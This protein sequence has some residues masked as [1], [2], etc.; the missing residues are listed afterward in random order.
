M[1]GRGSPSSHTVFFQDLKT[2][3]EIKLRILTKYSDA[4]Q[5][6]RGSTSGKLYYVDGFAGAGWYGDQVSEGKEGSPVRLA[7]LA[8]QIADSSKPYRLICLNCEVDHQNFSRLQQA[9]AGFDKEIVH[10][11]SGSFE[12]HLPDILKEIGRWPAV[13]FLDPFG[14]SPINLVNLHPIL[15]RPDTE[16]LLNLNTPS[17]RRIAGFADSQSNQRNAKLRIVSQVLGDDPTDPKPE[18]LDT[19]HRIAPIEWEKWAAA[20][21]IKRLQARSDYLRYALAYPIRETFRSNPKYYLVFATR[22]F[23]ASRS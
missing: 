17:L 11:Y 19:W 21:Y 13:F 4:Y 6:I 7:K 12:T 5:R 16:L 18:W 20:T 23:K 14:P 10:N 22:S 2:W 3:S 1:T 15:N 8:Q 9:L